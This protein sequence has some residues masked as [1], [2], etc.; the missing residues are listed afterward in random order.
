MKRLFTLAAVS[1]VTMSCVLSACGSKDQ[2]VETQEQTETIRIEIETQPESETEE[3]VLREIGTPAEEGGY[4]VKLTN[5]AEWDIVG[6]SVKASSE[7]EWG[8]N[9]FGEDDTVK[10]EEKVVIYCSVPE[11]GEEEETEESESRFA[12]R[13]TYDVQ[14]TFSKDTADNEVAD[15]ETTDSEASDE[16]AS[17]QEESDVVTYQ[18]TSFAFEDIEECTL[19]FEDEVAFIEYVSLDSGELVSTKEQELAV[20]E[21]AENAAESE[22]AEQT[23]APT[24]S[25]TAPTPAPVPEPAPAPAPTPAPEPAPAPEEPSYEV[26]QEWEDIDQGEEGCMGW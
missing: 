14:I 10:P 7:E 23:S 2:T 25:T 22:A 13:T 20:K 6:F 12:I 1:A 24:P 16:D 3:E 18:L 21:N 5:A 11:A 19:K 9:V 8:E 15:S 17:D 26:P 4:A